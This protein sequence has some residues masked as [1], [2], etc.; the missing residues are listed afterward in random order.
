MPPNSSVQQSLAPLNPGIVF[1]L[2]EIK[3][4]L[5]ITLTEQACFF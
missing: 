5:D 2:A 3:V 1:S 4:Q